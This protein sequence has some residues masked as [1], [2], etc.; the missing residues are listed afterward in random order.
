MRTGSM[1]SP[2]N[3]SSGAENCPRWNQP[4]ENCLGRTLSLH[5]IKTMAVMDK[6][7]PTLRTCHTQWSQLHG[8]GLKAKRRPTT[9]QDI[10][11]GY[12]KRPSLHNYIP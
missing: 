9:V 3:K 11:H 4:T 7:L 6:S 1:H 8:I 12:G 2:E 5:K 10:P